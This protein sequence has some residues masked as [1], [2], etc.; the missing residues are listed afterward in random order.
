MVLASRVNDRH[1]LSAGKGPIER[2][3]GKLQARLVDSVAQSGAPMNLDRYLVCGDR[4]LGRE[5]RDPVC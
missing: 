2:R 3:G 1:Q 5:F 4:R